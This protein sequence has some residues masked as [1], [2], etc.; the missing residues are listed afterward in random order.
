LVGT[1]GQLGAE[2]FLEQLASQESRVESTPCNQ[3]GVCPSL[4]DAALIDYQD[5]IC[6]HHGTHAVTHD[7]GSTTGQHAL[8]VR[9][10]LRFRVRVDGAQRV[11]ED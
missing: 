11:V 5:L 2:I 1:L 4:N 3:F 7:Q 6:I 8:Q 10:D 9:Q